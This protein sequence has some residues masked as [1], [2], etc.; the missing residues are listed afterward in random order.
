MKRKQKF[1]FFLLAII[2]IIVDILCLKCFSKKPVYIE[3]EA[4]GENC[5]SSL[6]MTDNNFLIE[7]EI[8]I[9]YEMF[10]GISVRIGN[11]GRENNSRYE[12]Q[13]IDTTENKQIAEFEFNTSSA[14]DDK[15]YELMLD[16]PKKIDSNHE[17][18]VL[19]RAK[20]PVNSENGVAFY[21]D[22]YSEKDLEFKYNG[23]PYNANLCMNVYGGNSNSFWTIFT[24]I[25]EINFSAYIIYVGYLFI[26]KKNIKSNS[27][28]QSGALGIILFSILSCF[29]RME[30]FCDEID[31]ML[32]G[33][34]INR[35]Y[36]LYVDY[37]TQ[38]TPI[39]YFMCAIFGIFNPTSVEQFRLIYYFIVSLLYS[40]LYLRHKDSFGKINMAILPIVQISFGLLL[41]N[42][43]VTLISDNLQAIS[44]TAMF[45]EFLQYLKDQKIDWKRSIII[46]LCI[47][48]SFGAAFVSAYAIAA[49]VLGVFIKE[50]IYWKEKKSISLLSIIKRYLKLF[51]LC[52]IPFVVVLGYTIFTHSLTEMYEQAFVF[53]REVYSTY[54]SDGLGSNIFQPFFIGIR[55]FLQ[56]IPNSIQNIAQNEQVLIELE[57]IFLG[58]YILIIFIKM[59]SKKEYLKAF[60]A[61]IFISFGFTR[62]SEPFHEI[63]AWF[64]IIVLA[65]IDTDFRK[66]NDFKSL[67]NFIFAIFVLISI[68]S[69]FG[70]ISEYVFKQQEPISVLEKQVIDNTEEG[71]KIFY[72]AFSYSSL[73]FM[74]KNRIPMNKLVYMLP[75]YFDWFELD[76]I[77]ELIN[78]KPKLV[79]YNEEVKA[80]NISGYDDYFRKVLHENY[81]QFPNNINIWK[82]K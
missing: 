52:L 47:C 19:I 41:A 9:P 79:I 20:S 65:I 76:T 70:K 4:V 42:E 50:I 45:L 66:I 17:Y 10:K 63:S 11:F 82:L 27:I 69:C 51:I 15:D 24:L 58:L 23:V 81:N 40:L 74:Y 21:V 61:F 43:S 46:S 12:L 26:K 80:W 77:N 5:I 54:L 68:S 3:Y 59:I 14:R 55:N 49:I 13:V 1:L 35:G 37:K 39:A 34:L 48:F 7:Q 32:G 28:I 57:K 38:H 30:T 6:E 67:E 75:W 64:A 62:T 22:N 73:Y 18:K 2:I 72:D 16:S 33:M 36:K 8:H 78:E 44:L 29:I 31:N 56:I 53:N 60:T 71:E 25:C